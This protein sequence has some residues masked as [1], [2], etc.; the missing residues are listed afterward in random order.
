MVGL[1]IRKTELYV[2][3]EDHKIWGSFLS[4]PGDGLTKKLSRWDKG[5]YRQ[6]FRPHEYC[7]RYILVNWL[8][9]LSLLIVIGVFW[10]CF[11]SP[12]GN[13]KSDQCSTFADHLYFSFCLKSKSRASVVNG[14]I[15]S[16][17]GSLVNMDKSSFRC[18]TD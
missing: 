12:L 4:R 8:S 11:P 14:R 5:N 9:C 17:M 7:Y 13:L 10:S 6:G 16:R 1:N 2:K 3:Q 18:M 15:K